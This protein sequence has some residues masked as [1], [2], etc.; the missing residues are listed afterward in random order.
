MSAAQPSGGRRHAFRGTNADLD[1]VYEAYSTRLVAQLYAY[2]GDLAL[3]EDLVQEAFVR[4]VPRWSKV[5]TYDDPVGWIRRV[6]W[7]LATSDWRR[8]RRA[9]RLASVT[10]EEHVPE[11]SPDR[12]VLVQ[13]LAALPPVQRRAVVMFYLAD[14]SL[15]DIAELERVSENTIKQRLHRGRTALAAALK[16]PRSEVGHA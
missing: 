14:M 7:N 1:E 2:T 4:V 8:A 10:R 3:A 15:S 6:A 5:S 11:P 13:A 9:R 16:E 12:V